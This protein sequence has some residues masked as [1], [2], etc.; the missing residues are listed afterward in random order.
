MEISEFELVEGL[1]LE[2]CWELYERAFAG[3][4]AAAVQRHLMYRD[5]FDGVMAD[6]RV[7]KLVVTDGTGDDL[8]IAALATFTNH[9]DAVPLI[10]PEYFAARWPDLHADGLIWYVGFLAVEPDYWRS[11]AAARIVTSIG[12][13]VASSGGIIAIDVCDRNEAT[14]QMSRG[15]LRFGR[16]I[17]VSATLHRLDAQTYWAY[18]IPAPVDLTALETAAAEARATGPE[19]R[20]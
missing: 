7:A 13:T 17:S 20:G 9:L 19:G 1:A 3:L 14:L 11:S 15:F 6:K 8:R 12:R 10:S 2:H 18:E 4:R 16:A 5:E